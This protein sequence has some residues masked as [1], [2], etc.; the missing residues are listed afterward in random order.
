[1]DI[2]GMIV[3]IFCMFDPV[4]NIPIVMPLVKDCTPKRQKIVILRE[5]SIALCVILLFLFLGKH[6]LNGLGIE[7]EA[8]AMTGGVILFLIGLDMSM[9]NKK[10]EDE[11][12]TNDD[13]EPFIV[14]IAIPLIAGPGVLSMIMVMSTEAKSVWHVIIALLVAWTVNVIILLFGQ[15]VAKYLGHRAMEALQ[16]LMGLA[17]TAISVQMFMNG[18]RIFMSTIP[19]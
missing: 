5:C 1:M 8:L 6:I 13:N 10:P 4:G 3:S 16:R 19:K 2:V 14:P 15:F 12:T 17:L 7:Q 9:S 11:V 18:F